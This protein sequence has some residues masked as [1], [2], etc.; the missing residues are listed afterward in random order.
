MED[1][2]GTLVKFS[3]NYY[4]QAW[5]DSYKRFHR[6][7]GPAVIYYDG[8]M[9]WIRHGRLHRDDGPAREWPARGIETWWKDGK[10]YE[11]SAHELMVWK[12][13]KKA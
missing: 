12:M 2:E 1:E 11:P 10:P 6:L 13:K 7:N 4:K 5:C 8:S 3:T 9:S